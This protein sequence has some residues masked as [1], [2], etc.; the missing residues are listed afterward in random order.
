MSIYISQDIFNA[1][2]TYFIVFALGGSVAIASSLIANTYI[3][4]LFAVMLAILLV[5][6][7]GPAFTYRIAVV[8]YLLGIAALL[9]LF[10]T[11]SELPSMYLLL[12]A[13]VLAGLGR[14][15]LNYIPWNV[16]MWT[17]L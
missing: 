2:F 4:Q 8:F 6:R 15:A 1:A 10:L 7:I 16:P 17:R 5:I 11:F 14:G 12:G 3:A 13:V 9:G